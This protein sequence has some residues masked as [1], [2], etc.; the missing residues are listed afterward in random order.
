MATCSQYYFLAY[1]MGDERALKSLEATTPYGVDN[2]HIYH[3]LGIARMRLEEVIAAR[4]Q[5]G[6]GPFQ[7]DLKATLPYL[8]PNPP[9]GGGEYFIPNPPPG[10]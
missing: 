3:A 1:L 9:S 4:A 10:G 5:R 8:K 6:L 7:M 2:S